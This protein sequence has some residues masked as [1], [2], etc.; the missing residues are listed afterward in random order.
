MRFRAAVATHRIPSAQ[1]DA[2]LDGLMGTVSVDAVLAAFAKPLEEGPI[3][4]RKSAIDRIFAADR[5]EDILD[6]LD[7]ET[8]SSS[9]DAEWATENCGHDTHQVAAQ[10]ENRSGSSPPRQALGFRGRAC[11]RNSA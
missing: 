5:V 4:Q 2:V 1:F 3:A 8:R 7:R 6:A 9:A 10:P 11:A